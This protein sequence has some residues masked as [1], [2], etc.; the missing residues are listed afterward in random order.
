[1]SRGTDKEKWFLPPLGGKWSNTG[2][3]FH[4]REVVGRTKHTR[5]REI[6]L[7]I[8]KPVTEGNPN[9]DQLSTWKIFVSLRG[10]SWV[11]PNKITHL[12]YSWEEAGTGA[13]DKDRWRIAPACI[14]WTIWKERN[15]RCFES[16]NCDLQM[17]KLNCVRLFCFWC[18]QIYL[19]DWLNYRHPRI[20]LE[21]DSVRCLFNFAV[22][23]VS[24]QPT[25]WLVNKQNS[26]LLKKKYTRNGFFPY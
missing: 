18:K 19:E 25:Y 24:V 22:N 20:L 10:I 8:T 6:R 17:I 11:M 21:L 23:M 7:P 16:K 1:M 2:E 4:L 14:L 5:I 12:L 3:W 15:S 26:Y 9:K 13:A